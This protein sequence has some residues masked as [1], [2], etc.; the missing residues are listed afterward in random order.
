LA[1]DRS[2]LVIYLG[3]EMSTE[4]RIKRLEMEQNRL[5]IIQDLAIAQVEEQIKARRT[6]QNEIIKEIG[7]KWGLG[8]YAVKLPDY[9][10]K[11]WQ[12]PRE[13][14]TEY[15]KEQLTDNFKNRI[16]EETH[17]GSPEDLEAAAADLVKK[18]PYLAT[19]G[20]VDDYY[21]YKKYYNALCP[22]GC[23]GDDASLAHE[24]ALD[25]LQKSLEENIYGAGRIN[26]SKPGEAYDRAFWTLNIKINK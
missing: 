13:L 5:Q 15:I 22:N 3:P 12:A 4:D 14:A 9:L 23:E 11:I 26:W 19:N 1:V 18:I 8:Q 25:Q 7:G 21:L 10:Q 16:L 20:C 17:G 6:V 24:T 2:Q